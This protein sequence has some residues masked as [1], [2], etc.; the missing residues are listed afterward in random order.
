V[1]RAAAEMTARL[2]A[3][4]TPPAGFI[5][6]RMAAPGVEMIAGVVREPQFGP[7]VACGAGGT[8][9]E[10]LGDVAIRLTPLAREEVREM[11]QE[12]KSYRLLT[13]FRGQPP[14]DVAALEEV[15]LRLGALAQDQ[16]AVAE[17]DCN[18]VIAH[19]RGATIVDVRVRVARP[20]PALPLGARR[21]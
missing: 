21:R 5:V 4:G 18:P 10:L 1:A 2:Q 16:P 9:V 14:A 7:V 19:T 8:L 6:Q 20:E 17:L 3:A 13:G 11:L 15:L 12:L